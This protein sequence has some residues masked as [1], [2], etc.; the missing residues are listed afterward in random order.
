MSA[1]NGVRSW[2]QKLVPLGLVLLSTVVA[3]LLGEL[4]V[5]WVVDPGEFLI[6][7]LIDD[8]ALGPRIK[9]NTTGHDAL[10]FRNPAVPEHANVVA[11]GDSQTYGV[12]AVRDDSWPYQLGKLLHQP[13][14]NMALG[15]YGPLQYLYLADQEARRLRPRLLLV[16]F[17]FG[18]DLI[19]ASRAAH[20]MPYWAEWGTAGPEPLFFAEDQGAGNAEPEKRFAALRD[21]LSR[22]SVVY[23][24]LRTTVLPRFAAWEADRMA[25]QA[26]PDRR[27]LW[28]DPSRNSVRTI[29]TP[30]LRLSTLD[31]RLPVVQEGLGITKRAFAALK[32][33]ARAQGAQL[34]V[35]LIPTK[36][37]AYCGY[38]RDSGA[39]MPEAFLALCENEQ[40]VK[41]E[42]ERALVAEQ[43][44]YVD[45]TGALE[46]KIKEHVQI[47]PKD[48][49]SHPQAAGYRAIAN[50]V[51]DALRRQHFLE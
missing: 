13:V 16:A 17:Y 27:M 14:Y 50:V 33:T 7:T 24:M 37:R 47:Y 29:F 44:A 22:H 11:I 6:A 35:V 18:N 2:L 30:Q 23:S 25:K 38:L 40:R 12:N 49:E 34:L 1:R 10:G 39:S 8:A 48:S 46:A 4:V 45:V 26:T 15:G 3:L 43:V 28:V 51:H 5:R 19:D 36:E 9:A 21:W 20:H 41:D 32:T 42:L 31:L